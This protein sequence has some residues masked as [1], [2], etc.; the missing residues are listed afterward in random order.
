MLKIPTEYD[1]NTSLDKFKDI[2][3][4]LAASLLGVCAATREALVDESGMIRT[5]MGTHN[6]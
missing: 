6:R 4:Q 1:R 3:R 2:F 5:Q